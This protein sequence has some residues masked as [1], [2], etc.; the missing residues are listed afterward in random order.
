MKRELIMARRT[1][2]DSMFD[3]DKWYQQQA[4]MAFPIL[5]HRAKARETITYKELGEALGLNKYFVSLGTVFSSIST[6]LADLQASWQGG[7]IPL[8]TNLVIKANGHPNQFVCAQLTGDPKKVP[9]RE[10]FDAVLEV[11]YN[12][13]NWDAIL[14]EFDLTERSMTMRT[15]KSEGITSLSDFT[16]WIVQLEPQSYL[17]RGV[18]NSAYEI[19]Q[20]SA[21][22]R[23]GKEEEPTLAK[24]IEINESVI[25]QAR[26][27]GYDLKNGR[28]LSDLEI[29]CEMQH[30]RVATCLIDFTYSAEVALWFACSSSSDEQLD[31]KVVAVR[32]DHSIKEVTS[33]MLERKIDDFFKEDE[34]E[35]YPLYQWQPT[36]LNNRVIRQHSVFLFG[37]GEIGSSPECI[38]SAAYKEKIRRELER[39]SN[40]S[41]DTLFPDFEGFS[42]LHAHNVPHTIPNYRKIAGEAYQQDDYPKAIANYEE[43]IRLDP[44]NERLYYMRGNAN[45]SQ[46]QYA[47]AIADY[48]RTIQLDPEFSEAYH[49]RG[50]AKH[51]LEEY[52]DA[53][54]DYDEATQLDPEFS[55]AYHWRGRAKHSL[56]EYADAI[57]DY[58][59]AT[60]LDVNNLHAYRYRS[61]AK[62]KV[63]KWTSAQQDLQLALLLA[64]KTGDAELIKEINKDISEIDKSL[65][66]S[67]DNIP[68]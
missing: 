40:I 52:A 14:R 42:R 63:E 57:A 64:E 15:Q 67:E 21:Y 43:A 28:A 61:K 2:Y 13:P 47:D 33:E 18:S 27:R 51:S 58:D 11:I 50:R 30:F 29:L 23:L 26:R 22:R 16:E 55:E 10:E 25:E 7:D 59:E 3:G 65:S 8:I 9:T 68:F 36:H 12:Y 46:R 48:N 62:M 44:D 41:E 24:L 54:A 37:G 17:F 1:K 56:E 5:V 60:R 53:I 49:W 4:R 38:I 34:I 31:G 19:G 6:T 45:L 66:V 35:G 39:F 32:N 20:A